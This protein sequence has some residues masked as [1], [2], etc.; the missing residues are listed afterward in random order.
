MSAAVPTFIKH[1]ISTIRDDKVIRTTRSLRRAEP[2]S[3]TK[4]QPQNLFDRTT[5]L[6]INASS[7]VA[8]E[9]TFELS[10]AMPG[11]AV[12]FAPTLDLA[13]WMLTRRKIELVVATPAFADGSLASLEQHLSNLETPPELLVLGAERDVSQPTNYRFAGSRRLDRAL[14]DL[15]ADIRND[16]N[17]PLQEI[18]AMAFVAQATGELSP[19]AEQALDAIENAAM[20]LSQVV[21]ALEGKIRGVM[22]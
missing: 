7:D 10:R 18:V 16:L 9:I 13:M 4:F 2:I 20:N 22:V 21:N 6:V 3:C 8:R 19:V 12:L 11:I 1:Q 15:G 17:N 5:A 14:S